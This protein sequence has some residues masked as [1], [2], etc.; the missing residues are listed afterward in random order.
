VLLRAVPPCF[1]L[2]LHR[3]RLSWPQSPHDLLRTPPCLAILRVYTATDARGCDL[4]EVSNSNGERGGDACYKRAVGEGGAGHP[5]VGRGAWHQKSSIDR[6][7]VE[8]FRVAERR[9][10]KGAGIGFGWPLLRLLAS[11]HE[12]VRVSLPRGGR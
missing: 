12:E 9:K 7:K 2:R 6:K 4:N 1:P 11:R 10:K 8:N 5:V 3:W